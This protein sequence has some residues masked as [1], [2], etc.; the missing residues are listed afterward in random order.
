MTALRKMPAYDGFLLSLRQRWSATQIS[1]MSAQF[2][3]VRSLEQ[4]QHDPQAVDQ[5]EG[6]GIRPS[7]ALRT[8]LHRLDDIV[9][10]HLHLTVDGTAAWWVKQVLHEDAI[11]H[12]PP[13][14]HARFDVGEGEAPPPAAVNVR[15]TTE[16][17]GVRVTQ[18]DPETGAHLWHH[19]LAT[20]ELVPAWVFPDRDA[21]LAFIKDTLAQHDQAQGWQ[22][23]PTTETRTLEHDIPALMRWYVA[24]DSPADESTR[25]RLQGLARDVLVL[26]PPRN[27]RKTRANFFADL[28]K[29]GGYSGDEA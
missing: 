24:G 20:G 27:P 22:H 28:A 14:Y 9:A 17:F 5:Y 15:I 16:G 4:I 25:R 13:P 19:D 12:T 2:V 10:R 26:D 23:N 6:W 29:K 11:E 1:P 18:H 21:A 8:Y 3:T 7:P